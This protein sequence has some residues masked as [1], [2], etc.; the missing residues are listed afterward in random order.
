MSRPACTQAD[1]VHLR[2]AGGG[3]IDYAYYRRRAQR[4]RRWAMQIGFDR[5]VRLVLRP[6]MRDLKPCDTR[7]DMDATNMLRLMAEHN[8]W[9][10]RKLYAVCAQLPEAERT[11]D[12]GAFFR[13]VH[14]TLNHLLLVDR[15]WLGRLRHT[16]FRVDSLDQAL[17]HDF[18]EL[19]RER[20]A[21]DAALQDFVARL[22]Q[23]RLA[24]PVHYVSLLARK[25]VT[26]PLGLILMHLSH[27]QTHHRGQVTAL[28]SRL[29]Y[30]FG[31]TDMICMP[32][33]ATFFSAGTPSRPIH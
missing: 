4:L 2:R 6:R 11:R 3:G 31:D 29:G 5:L 7:Q 22:D 16:P 21:T 1:N 12:L 9:M 13:S 27:H 28:L 26:L 24:E 18:A 10:N 8:R 15:L 25:P 19:D 17:Y 32:G 20:D 30:D 14:G 33:A 23:S